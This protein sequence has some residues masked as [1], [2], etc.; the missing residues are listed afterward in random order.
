MN[1]KNNIIRKKCS[2]CNQ[3]SRGSK[4]KSRASKANFMMNLS[5]HIQLRKIN[6]WRIMGWRPYKYHTV[7]VANYLRMV[8]INRG[9]INNIRISP[10]NKKTLWIKKCLP[11]AETRQ[12]KWT[13]HLSL[14]L[15]RGSPWAHNSLP[16]ILSRKSQENRANLE[17]DT[18]TDSKI[19]ISC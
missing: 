12:F 17:I 2:K 9:K 11:L 18:W 8:I 16:K 7:R 3:I 6:L 15:R 19:Q 4:Q 13:W 5:N 10:K 1:F 14:Q